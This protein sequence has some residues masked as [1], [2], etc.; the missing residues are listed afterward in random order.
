M[1]GKKQE[2]LDSPVDPDES[3]KTRLIG[4]IVAEFVA[5]LGTSRAMTSECVV[6][7]GERRVDGDAAPPPAQRPARSGWF[8]GRS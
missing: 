2:G 6:N 3:N 8:C 1:E 7:F 4:E 5:S